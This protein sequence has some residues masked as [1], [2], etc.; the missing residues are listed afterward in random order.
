MK[1]QDGFLAKMDKV[2]DP[3]SLVALVETVRRNSS[4]KAFDLARLGKH[5]NAADEFAKIELAYTKAIEKMETF[6]NANSLQSLL[7]SLQEAADYWKE[8][9]ENSRTEDLQSKVDKAWDEGREAFA[10]G[11]YD[12]ALESFSRAFNMASTANSSKAASILIDKGNVF[13]SKGDF[14]EAVSLYEQAVSLDPQSSTAL[15]NKGLALYNLKDLEDSINAFDAALELYENDAKVLSQ[16]GQSLIELG[17]YD[18]AIECLNRATKIDKQDYFAYY[19][20]GSALNIRAYVLEKERGKELTE[21][22]YR[23][24]LKSYEVARSIDPK[25]PATLKEMARTYNNLGNFKEA[26]ECL[27]RAINLDPND[28]ESVEYRAVITV[29]IGQPRES[30]EFY[31]RA[32]ELHPDNL[33][34]RMSFAEAQLLSGYFQKSEVTAKNTL[35]MT[36][37]PVYVYIL[38]HMIVCSLCLRE[39]QGAIEEATDLLTYYKYFPKDYDLGFWDF[40]ALRKFI[41]ES[42]L[43]EVKKNM[44]DL[45]MVTIEEKRDATEAIDELRS[46]IKQETSIINRVVD[47]LRIGKTTPAADKEFK[48]I[49]TATPVAGKAGW[50]DWEIYFNEPPERLT[51]IQSVTY[52]LH[53]TFPNPE[54]TVYNRAEQFLLRSRGW[55]SFRVKIIVKLKNGESVTKYHWLDLSATPDKPAIS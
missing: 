9:S 44:L 45:L 24:A 26:I 42:Q 16:K 25:N 34:V 27:D 15:Y 32:I 11:S 50:Y 41:R 55:G 43:S 17:R 8:R 20:L 31:S 13:F 28:F 37:N 22:D 23:E 35:N 49:S 18:E 2:T 4:Q 5:A 12:Q 29:N 7:T 10:K 38:R 39:V 48:T 53:P 46:L 30:L 19:A 36:T 54:R 21:N 6:E 1:K 14:N 51:N 47:R 40:T 3:T 52:V 33:P